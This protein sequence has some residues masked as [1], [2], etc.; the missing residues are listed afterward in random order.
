MIKKDDG[1][2]RVMTAEIQSGDYQ[3]LRKQFVQRNCLFYVLFDHS[4]AEFSVPDID[5]PG[6]KIPDPI[7]EELQVHVHEGGS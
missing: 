4:I 6:A 1:I 2:T 3:S 5:T 7:P